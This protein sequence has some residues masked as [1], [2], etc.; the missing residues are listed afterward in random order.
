MLRQMRSVRIWLD[1]YLYWFK[2][3][4]KQYHDFNLHFD[5]S[6][7]VMAYFHIEPAQNYS[8]DV[9]VSRQS[10]THQSKSGTYHELFSLSKCNNS[11]T[12]TKAEKMPLELGKIV[13]WYPQEEHL[14]M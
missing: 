12:E 13:V 1:R 7:D 8:G 9:Q 11:W 6:V 4:I 5:A 10:R 14:N 3:P 2:Q